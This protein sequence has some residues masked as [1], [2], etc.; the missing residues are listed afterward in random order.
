MAGKSINQ[1][2][3][4]LY[5]KYRYKSGLTQ[6]TSAAKAGFSTRSAYLIEKGKHHTQQPNV[7][8]PKV[9]QFKTGINLLFCSK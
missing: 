1:Q 8:L 3:V 9:R 5:M 2:Q 4:K 7:N 6:E